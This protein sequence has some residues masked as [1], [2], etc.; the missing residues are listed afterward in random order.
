MSDLNKLEY[1]IAKF[2]RVGVLISGLLILT[3][4]LISVKFSSVDPFF[5]FRVYDTFP[6]MNILKL[7]YRNQ[8]WG[9][10]ISYLGLA[11]LIS[12]P[13]IR[14]LLTGWLFFRQKDYLLSFIALLV[15]VALIISFGLGLEL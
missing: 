3:G 1:K 10:L 9:I 12:L 4:W 7:Y 11:C 8:N 5:S 14:V 13:L 15:L 2:L 6:L